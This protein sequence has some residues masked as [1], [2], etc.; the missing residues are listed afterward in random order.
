MLICQG[1]GVD[2][3]VVK[4]EKNIFL[5]LTFQLSPADKDIGDTIVKNIMRNLDLTWL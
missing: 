3:V 2:V 4:L 5:L 1:P